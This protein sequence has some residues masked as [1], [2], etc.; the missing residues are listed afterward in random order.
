MTPE[1]ELIQ[2]AIDVLMTHSDVAEIYKD[3]DKFRNDL[4]SSGRPIDTFVLAAFELINSE[5]LQPQFGT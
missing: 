5:R 2:L 1:Q 3:T 4:K